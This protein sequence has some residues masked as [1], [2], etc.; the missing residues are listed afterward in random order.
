MLHL[1]FYIESIKEGANLLIGLGG[2]CRL[3]FFFELHKDIIEDMGKDLIFV[4]FSQ[5]KATNLKAWYDKIKYI[6]TNLSLVELAKALPVIVS[7]IKSISG[8]EDY[9]R[10]IRLS[11]K[12]ERI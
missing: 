11:K 2:F 12:Y 5:T 10:K 7:M 3:D 9:I 4:N 6:N 1:N 8:F